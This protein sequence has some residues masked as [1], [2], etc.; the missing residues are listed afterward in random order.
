MTPSPYTRARLVWGQNC[1]VAWRTGVEAK[2]SVTSLLPPFLL[3]SSG[4]NQACF[5]GKIS[6][7]CIEICLLMA[8]LIKFK[9][10]FNYL[11]DY[12]LVWSNKARIFM[13][14]WSE[15]AASPV[16]IH[17]SASDVCG[18]SFG[19]YLSWPLRLVLQCAFFVAF[20]LFSLKYRGD[21]L[22]SVVAL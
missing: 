17:D 19:C 9:E 4:Y 15:T 1:L 6:D 10:N 16:D 8:Q 18:R 21:A 14:L 20:F 2:W 22:Y 7:E 5:E 3:A 13:K 12:V 11:M